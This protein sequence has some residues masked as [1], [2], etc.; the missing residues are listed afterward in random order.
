MLCFSC[1]S[2]LCDSLLLPVCM[3]GGSVLDLDSLA[4]F[5][6]LLPVN[7]GRFTNL[8]S[9]PLL[10]LVYADAQ[11]LWWFFIFLSDLF[12]ILLLLKVNAIS[13]VKRTQLRKSSLYSDLC[14]QPW[15]NSNASLCR[16]DTDMRK[17]DAIRVEKQKETFLP[18]LFQHRFSPGALCKMRFVCFGQVWNQGF[19]RCAV[20]LPAQGAL[21]L[22]RGGVRCPLQHFGWSH[23]ARQV[24]RG[25]PALGTAR[26]RRGGLAEQS[27]SS[28]LGI[29][30]FP[31]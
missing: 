7:S 2:C 25:A 30:S 20:R 8:W 1:F 10:W 18:C 15:S 27:C 5:C 13:S 4:Q 14:N 16:R 24:S 23:Q 12:C 11:Q 19:L 22:R 6:L 26:R 17:Q 9:S 28:H 29:P 21:P 3:L 31:V